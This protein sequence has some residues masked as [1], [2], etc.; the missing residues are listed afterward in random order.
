L[1][2]GLEIIGQEA[3][4]LRASEIFA[5]GRQFGWEPARISTLFDILIDD[6]KIVTRVQR[7]MDENGWQR[8]TRTFK[9]DGEVVSDLLRRYTAQWGLPHGF[10]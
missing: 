8:W 1:R 7:T 3:E 6:A 5:L 10:F 2:G 9:P 4:G